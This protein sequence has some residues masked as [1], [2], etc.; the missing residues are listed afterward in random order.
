M[1]SDKAEW[2]IL[3]SKEAAYFPGYTHES[4]QAIRRATRIRTLNVMM[5]SNPTAYNLFYH[6]MHNVHSLSTTHRSF[7]LLT[8]SARPPSL[9]PLHLC[10]LFSPTNDSPS[11]CKSITNSVIISKSSS[12]ES[13]SI[14]LYWVDHGT[15]GF[16]T[17]ATNAFDVFSESKSFIKSSRNAGAR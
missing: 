2:R 16:L 17:A 14:P 6:T 10:Y 11:S 7:C 5:Y 9:I 4:K 8:V 3:S 12:I 15:G 13:N 1:H